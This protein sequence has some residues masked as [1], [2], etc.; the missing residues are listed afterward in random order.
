MAPT[1]LAFLNDA[2]A[3]LLGE[4]AAGAAH[5]AE[6]AIGIALGTGIGSAFAVNGEWVTSGG[7]VPPGGEI[8]NYPYRGGIVE[9]LIS[10][11]ALRKDYRDRTGRD[12]EVAAIAAAAGTDADAR[13]VFE[14]FGTNLGEVLR[15][16]CGKF[17]PAIVVIGGGISRS[18]QLFLPSAEKQLHGLGFTLVPARLLD[19]AHLVGAAS[20]WRR[21]ATTLS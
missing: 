4:A 1:Q 3:F 15:D 5:G 2:A 9:D 10:T 16:V 12:E 11:R 7:G 8:W 19:E 17:A 13:V 20:Y 21:N 14:Q 6:R 18:A